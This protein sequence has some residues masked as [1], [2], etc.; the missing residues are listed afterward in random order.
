MNYEKWG[1]G[2]VVT[3]KP[4]SQEKGPG[5]GVDGDGECDDVD[6]RM[7]KRRDMRMRAR[8][9]LYRA[10]T[11]WSSGDGALTC[12]VRITWVDLGWGEGVRR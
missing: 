4:T 12:Q 6:G 9:A 7:E 3:D 2:V 1:G 5:V 8:A 10:C 11:V